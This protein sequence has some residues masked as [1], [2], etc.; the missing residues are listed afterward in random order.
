MSELSFIWRLP[1]LIKLTLKVILTGF[2]SF[3]ALTLFIELGAFGKL[4]KIDRSLLEP[5]FDSQIFYAD[6]HTIQYI[7]DGANDVSY[8]EISPI[9][10][11]FYL[12]NN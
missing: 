9:L 2:A 11:K 5:R 10:I 3:L 4:T 6:G 1:F 7:N 8:E 12:H